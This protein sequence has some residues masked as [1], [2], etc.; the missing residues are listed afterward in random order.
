MIPVEAMRYEYSVISTLTARGFIIVEAAG[1][2]E[3]RLDRDPRHDSGAIMV[4]AADPG[5]H[6][7]SWFTNWGSRVDVHGWGSGIA[8]LGSGEDPAGRPNASMRANGGDYRQWYMG[9]F[10]GTSG[11]S[12]IVAGAAAIIQSNRRAH[13]ARLL[14]A[15]AMRS[16]LICTGTPQANPP[17]HIGPQ[18]DLRRAL[19]A[20]ALIPGGGAPN[21]GRP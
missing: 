13:R 7:P 15:R 17:H 16:L 1:N 12:P 21:C 5:T 8:T 11:A 9:D 2:G 3:Q 4:G 14:D 19:A 20:S 10:G 18:P 6:Q